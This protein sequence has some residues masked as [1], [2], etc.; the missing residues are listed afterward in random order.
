MKML[1][2]IAVFASCG[3]P[4]ESQT[5]P[6]STDREIR[7]ALCEIKNGDSAKA[8]NAL[9]RILAQ[10][11]NNIYSH[12]LLPGTLADQIIKGNNTQANIE[13][14]RKAIDAYSKFSQNEM[15]SKDERLWANNLIPNLYER[16]SAEETTKALLF[17]AQDTARIAEMRSSYYLRLA[18]QEKWLADE[19]ISGKNRLSKVE[20]A[21]ATDSITK[22][23]GFANEAIALDNDN[24]SAWSYKASLLI[25]ASKIAGFEKDLARKNILD[26]EAG[27]AIA[28]FK[29]I[30]DKRRKAQDAK[31]TELRSKNESPD[32]PDRIREELLEYRAEKPLNELVNE[33]YVPLALS[34]V[35]P[36][37]PST[38]RSSKA[39]KRDASTPLIQWKVFSPDGR[40]SVL[41][42][43]VSME[44]LGRFTAKSDRVDYTLIQQTRPAAPFPVSD[45]A[46]LNTI[47][48]S[49]VIPLKNFALMGDSP[50]TFESRLSKKGSIGGRPARIYAIKS[51]FCSK[52]IE[53]SLVLLAGPQSDYVLLIQG[54][55]QGDPR[56]ARVIESLKINSAG[57]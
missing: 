45:D 14:I 52:T 34:L 18:V 44:A 43:K 50:A 10:E 8:Q 32:P 47:A 30:A 16:I 7:A 24:E 20:I 53:S 21:R 12:R 5:L 42:P 57:N 37:D 2:L 31:D 27:I 54:A 28:G 39:L 25:L 49:V 33:I 15:F 9:E 41:L 56:A 46:V 3:F 11:P 26:K 40:L 1:V 55:G 48:W 19:I 4:I 23:L 29:E 35:A 36:V 6:D 51:I 17:G 22:G 13:R 38:R